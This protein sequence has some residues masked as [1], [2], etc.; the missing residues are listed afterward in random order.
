MTPGAP[1]HKVR[2]G[3]CTL[4]E[5]AAAALRPSAKA[6]ADRLSHHDAGWLARRSVRWVSL[7]SAINRIYT[8]SPVEEE[9]R[10]EC[11]R[12]GSRATWA[13]QI[14]FCCEQTADQG[15][16]AAARGSIPRI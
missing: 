16:S 9:D 7:Y 13:R 14:V 11:E 3:D 4:D 1:H 10:F 15:W 8:S 6:T 12:A 2:D 5:A